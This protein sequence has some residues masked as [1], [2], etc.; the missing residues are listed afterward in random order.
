LGQSIKNGPPTGSV[1]A[2][3]ARDLVA[4]LR[5]LCIVFRVESGITCRVESEP[6]HLYCDAPLVDLVSRRLSALLEAVSKRAE[7]KLVILSLGWRKDGSVLIRVDAQEPAGTPAE[8]MSDTA[9]MR[10]ARLD[11]RLLAAGIHSEVAYSV[12][13]TRLIV[14]AALVSVD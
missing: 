1:G 2:K 12:F 13:S 5:E 7:A 8:E 14:P 10:F 6:E 11:E 3:R 4:M 9:R